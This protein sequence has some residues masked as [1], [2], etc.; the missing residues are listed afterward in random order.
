MKYLELE[1]LVVGHNYVCIFYDMSE[2]C[3]LTYIGN[4]L[5][6]DNGS[7]GTVIYSVYGDIRYVIKQV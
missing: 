6:K 5:F 4:G 2:E 7:V 3:D 1:Q